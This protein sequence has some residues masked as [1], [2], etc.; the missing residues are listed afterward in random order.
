MQREIK[1]IAEKVFS[2]LF[3]LGVAGNT[4]SCRVSFGSFLE[5]RRAALP[6]YVHIYA[7]QVQQL[8]GEEHV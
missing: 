4:G 8:S 6:Y 1:R 7:S 2:F 3:L 5:I